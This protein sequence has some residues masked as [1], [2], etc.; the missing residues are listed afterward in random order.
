MCLRVSFRT[1]AEHK[2]NSLLQSMLRAQ[3]LNVDGDDNLW[4]H[5]SSF[6]LVG[7]D[8]FGP[9]S[10]VGMFTPEICCLN[11]AFDNLHIEPGESNLT[12]Q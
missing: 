9:R 2:T 8:V 12:S 3:N 4:R 7:A 10:L 5:K 11:E 6:L 1:R